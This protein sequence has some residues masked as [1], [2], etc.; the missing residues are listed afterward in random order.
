MGDVA[1]VHQGVI[2]GANDVFILD[3]GEVPSDEEAVYRPFL[4]ERMIG[5]YILPEDTGKKVFYPFVDGVPVN[6][7]QMEK[8]FPVTWDRINQHRDKLSSRASA[9]RTPSGWWQPSWPRSPD[10]IFVP[11][12]VVPKLSLVPRFGVDLSGRW[13]VSHSPLVSG[14]FGTGE[15]NLLL[16]AAVLNSSV[17]AW[18]IDLQGRKFQRG[19]SEVT[20]SL[21][22]RM[23][24]PDFGLVPNSVVRQVIASVRVLVSSLERFDDDAASS[25]DDLVL[26]DLYLLDDREIDLLRPW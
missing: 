16:L 8:D 4:P 26:R 12:V 3:S 24:V 10:R 18:Y 25:L 13:V 14:R 21:L 20:V 9:R 7:S 15:D 6:V 23:P 2:T 19:Y 5:R 1:N 22:R 17:A 11:K